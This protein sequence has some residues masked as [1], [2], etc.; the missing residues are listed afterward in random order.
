VAD[1][2][3]HGHIQFLGPERYHPSGLHRGLYGFDRPD[4]Q[5]VPFNPKMNLKISAGRNSDD[6]YY[7]ISFFA[8]NTVASTNKSIEISANSLVVLFYYGWRL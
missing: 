6:R 2:G 4:E 7:G 5:S 8:D 1:N 3:E